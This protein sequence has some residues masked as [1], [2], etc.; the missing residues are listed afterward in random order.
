MAGFQVTPYGRFW[1]TPKEICGATGAMWMGR[2]L[3]HLSGVIGVQRP[4][5]VDMK[6]ILRIA[7]RDLPDS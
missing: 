3:R 7:T 2:R 6:D 5:R 1:V 4:K